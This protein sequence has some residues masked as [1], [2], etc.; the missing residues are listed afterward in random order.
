[1]AEREVGEALGS[2]L[3]HIATPRSQREGWGVGK[4]GK[5]RERGERGRGRGEVGAPGGERE[6]TRE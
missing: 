6:E 5:L 4:G 3:S 2:R 1:M